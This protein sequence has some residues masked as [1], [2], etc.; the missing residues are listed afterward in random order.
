MTNN[1]SDYFMIYD[2][3]RGESEPRLML[4]TDGVSLFLFSRLNGI[5]RLIAT[6]KYDTEKHI[7]VGDFKS[8]IET[9]VLSQMAKSF[10]LAKVL[11]E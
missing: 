8:M 7:A 10:D 3:N 4:E 9:Q 2:F 11:F 5:T 6:Y 1:N